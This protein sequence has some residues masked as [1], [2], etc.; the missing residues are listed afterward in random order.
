M[1]D[2]HFSNL[3]IAEQER[4]LSRARSLSLKRKTP[5]SIPIVRSDRGRPQRLSFAQERL[6][7]LSQMEGG[8]EAYHMPYG[9]SLRGKL[10]RRALGQALDRIVARHE[11]LRTTFVMVGEEPQQRIAPVEQSPFT[12]REHDL[13]QHPEAQHELERLMGE[14]A[15]GKFDPEHGTLARGRLVRIGEEDYWLLITMH[16]I[17]SDGW[18]IGVL[19][20]ELS[21][22]YGALAQ[23]EEDPL[24]ELAVQYADYAVWQ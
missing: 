2:P 18:S 19:F 23:G 8:S 1:R 10:D 4:F 13:R 21:A 5:A 7:F 22:L 6:W 12:L 9:I 15:R 11:A 17:V 20:Q 3:T 14:Q 16:H 24:P